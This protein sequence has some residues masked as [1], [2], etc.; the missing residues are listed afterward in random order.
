MYGIEGANR[1]AGKSLTRAL[2]HLWTDAQDVPVSR[3]RRQVRSSIR[4]IGFRQF[5]K[6]GGTH[7][8]AVALNQCEV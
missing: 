5:T 3:R 7:D 2:H 4:G 1:F 8:Y 6:C